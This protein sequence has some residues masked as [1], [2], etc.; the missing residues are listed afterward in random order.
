MEKTDY[1]K[2]DKLRVQLHEIRMAMKSINP[3]LSTYERLKKE[4]EKTLKELKAL[5]AHQ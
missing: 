2:K 4:E 1:A 3:K 5:G